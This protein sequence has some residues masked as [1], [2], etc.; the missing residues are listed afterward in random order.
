MKRFHVHMS[1]DDIDTARS[2]YSTLFGAEPTVLEVDYAKWMLDDPRVN[3][4]VS[5]RGKTP[6]LD[7]LGIQVDSE[8]DLAE[9]SGRI[10]AAGVAQIAQPNAACCYAT[11]SKSWSA[12]PSG[13]AWETFHTVGEIVTYGDDS[14]DTR[15]LPRSSGACCPSAAE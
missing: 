13:I 12:D 11:G 10:A 7:H 15:N 2:F 1:V 4:A 5:T 6:G 14:V 9:V 8:A 3:F